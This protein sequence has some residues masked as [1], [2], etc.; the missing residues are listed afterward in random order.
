VIL[1]EWVKQSAVLL[2]RAGI[3]NAK[4]E[5]YHCLSHISGK[6]RAFFLSRAKEPME[7]VLSPPERQRLEEICSRR[8]KN[9]PLE[10]ILGVASFWGH[11]FVVGPGVLIPR[12]DSET[13]I[14]VVL[15]AVGLW[16]IPAPGVLRFMDLCTGS[17]CLGIAL[18]HALLEK[19]TEVKGILTDISK[20]ALAYADQN[21]TLHAMN[22]T[23]TLM[24]C[25]LV[26]ERSE[27]I[28]FWG[29]YLAD[30]I[31]TNPP[32]IT[33]KDMSELLPEVAAYEP[34]V[35]LRGG[36]DGLDF[37]RRILI[38]VQPYLRSGGLLVMEH[39]YDQ[40]ESVPELCR[41]FGFSDVHCFR[42]YGGQP[43]VTAAKMPGYE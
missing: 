31:V 34:H 41:S 32:Y 19:N 33:D 2:E 4:S 17:G 13:V 5:P 30:L 11:S 42:D 15:G 18:A 14:E 10:Y 28:D 12:P 20:D 7:D 22:K 8:Q 38:E 29:D 36:A 27:I 6:N 23:L 25:D 9:E 16:K 24:P 39:G 43:R 40:G 35:A 26:P 3:E 37:Y 21:I 1:S